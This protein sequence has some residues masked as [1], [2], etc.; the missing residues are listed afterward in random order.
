[1]PISR[2]CELCGKPFSCS[3][4]LAGRKAC[5]N[6]C[7]KKIAGASRKLPDAIKTCEECGAA[8]AVTR[9][10]TNRRF[11]QPACAAASKARLL[12]AAFSAPRAQ[13]A[14]AH[15]KS[16]FDV[17]DTPSNAKR[18][19]CSP[20]CANSSRR[21]SVGHGRVEKL[22]VTCAVCGK[23]EAIHPCRSKTYKFCSPICNGAHKAT[24]TGPAHPR[25]SMVDRI[26]QWCGEEFKC[27]PAKVRYG[28]GLYCAR[29]CLGSAKSKL[30]QGR[31]SSIEILTEQWLEARGIAYE[32]QVQV[33]PWVVDF[34]LTGT[35]IVLECD[36]DYWHSLPRSVARDRQK[37][38]WM[39]R[40]GRMIVRLRESA[41][42]AGDYSIL[43]A[44][45]AK[46][47]A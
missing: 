35:G 28:E 25:Y 8:F 16:D 10:R 4:S 30:Q 31:R 1:M 9:D 12:S 20:Q 22:Q 7:A 34:V 43:E 33:G 26:C 21:G 45:L 47:A 46:L 6:E 15:C 17:R 24:I 40:N 39:Y 14:C 19:F 44:S 2:T 23:R 13:R 36:G 5:S 29:R 37:N 3:P 11:C 27:K 32:A 41:I 38:G 42:N 18:R